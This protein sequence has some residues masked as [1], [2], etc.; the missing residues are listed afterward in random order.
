MWVVDFNRQSLDR[1][2]PGVRIDQWRGQFEAAGWHVVEVKY[3]R[4][5]A[6]GVRPARR[7]GVAG[8]DRRDAQRAVPVA[9][10]AWRATRC[11]SSSSTAHR[12]TSSTGRRRRHATTTWHAL[13]TD[14][15]GHDIAAMLDAYAAVRRRA[16]T[17]RA[18]SSPT[19]SRAGACRSRATRATTPRCCRR[20]RSTRC[21]TAIGSDRRDRVGP[22]STPRSPAGICATRAASA[23]RREP[24]RAGAADHG[25]GRDRRARRRS[26]CRRRRPSA[27]CSSTSRATTTS[28]RT[29][30]RPHPTSPPR[31]TWPGSS[32]AIGV[33]APTQRRSW[34]ED[35][36]LQWAEGPIGPAH[37]ARHLG[38]EPVPAA[39]PARARR[40]TSP[41]S[42]CSRSARSTTRSCCRGLDAFIYAVYSGSRFVVA[43]TPSGV[44]LAPEGGAH[45]STITASIGLEL[46][47]RDRS[48]SR[49]TPRRSTGCSATRSAGSPPGPADDHDGDALG[50]RRVLLPAHDPAARPGAVRG[51]PPA[52]RRRGAAAAG[53]GRRLPARR[54]TSRTGGRGRGRGA[55]RAPGRHRRGAARGRGR[56]QPSSPTRGSSR[57]SST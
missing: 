48:S 39:R 40:G 8:V 28:R 4:R 10:R 30:S 56:R 11:A 38:D 29:S 6:G 51:G 27:A 26:R 19:P 50:Q 43:G 9:V 49:R 25:P 37:R 22:A 53:A 55:G 47:G 41:G 14:L 34:S 42:R 16:A 7:S 3:G 36:V 2:V 24:P 12:P 46:P 44:T 31:P 15:G 21:A 32:T 20:R 18:S 57:T 33:F 13:V 35:P 45:Q 1:V 5:L 54:R 17:G 52:D 23:L